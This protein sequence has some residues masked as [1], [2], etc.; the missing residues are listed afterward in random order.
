[1]GMPKLVRENTCRWGLGDRMGS[2]FRTGPLVL[3]FVFLDFFSYW[4]LGPWSFLE[5]TI[6]PS[7]K[8]MRECICS[9]SG[10]VDVASSRPSP[11]AG[12]RSA[13]MCIRDFD[14]E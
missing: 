1:M 14:F 4:N 2:K 5:T 8:C 11:S 6:G 9:R 7:W 3:E 10:A 12:T 13:L